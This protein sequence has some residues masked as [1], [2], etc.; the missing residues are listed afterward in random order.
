MEN[1][2]T[3]N[4][5]ELADS[6]SALNPRFTVKKKKC[7]QAFQNFMEANNYFGIQQPDLRSAS[8]KATLKIFARILNYGFFLMLPVTTI[9]SSF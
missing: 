5:F 8:N 4:I 2:S 1:N 3:I 7:R 9:N 6:F